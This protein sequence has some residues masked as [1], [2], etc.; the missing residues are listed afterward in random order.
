MPLAYIRE[1]CVDTPGQAMAAERLGADRIEF[2]GELS[3]GGITPQLP[4]LDLAL[5]TVNIPLRVMLRPRGGHFH[6]SLAERQLLLQQARTLQRMGVSE[7]VTGALTPEGRLDFSLLHDLLS[8]QPDWGITVHKVIDESTDPLADV[9]QLAALGGGFSV[10][11]SGGGATAF[12]GLPR[13]QQLLQV[14]GE[15]VQLVAC[16][17]VSQQNLP[18][19]HRLL[20]AR[21]YHGRLI[22]GGLD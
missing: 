9:A 2:C 10:L 16:G 12:E 4:E 15:A 3:L 14:A 13:L 22:V 21:A 11:S 19:L 17:K 6:Y 5:Q 7:L 18:E 1:A 8:I 20:Q